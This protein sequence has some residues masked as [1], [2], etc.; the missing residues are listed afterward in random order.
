MKR[1][2]R[3]AVDSSPAVN[4]VMCGVLLLG[5]ASMFMMRREVFPEFSLDIILVSV[6]Y[7][8][9][10]PDEVEQG[11]CQ[12]IEESVRS[13]E[14]IK[15]QTA[16]AQEGS[17]FLVLELQ[18]G[19]DVQKI[20]NDVRSEIDRIPS[21]PVLAEDH[22]VEQITLRESA[23]KVAVQGPELAGVD[24]ELELRE[25]TER[26][27]EDLIQLPAVSQ[28]NILGSR[29]YQIDVEVSEDRLRTYGLTLQ[30][31][32]AKIREENI[33]M[34]GGK[35][36]TPNQEVLVRGKNKRLYGHDIAQIPL[37]TKESGVVLTVGDL[38][39]VSDAFTDDTAISYVNG[40]PALVISMDRT[41][42]EDL[43]KMVDEV[44]RYAD[45][46]TVP[47]GY[48][49]VAFGDRSLEVRDRMNLLMKNGMQGLVLVFLMLTVFM[50]LRLSFWVAL[51]IP[52]AVLGSGIFLLYFGQTLNM[53]SLFAFLMA[54]GIVV[55]DAI[56]I[57]ENIFSHRQKGDGPIEAAINGT[58]EVIPSVAAS[59]TTTIIAFSPLLFVSGVMGKFIA[60]MPV[61]VIAMLVIS[62][63]ESMII[64]PCHLAHSGGDNALLRLFQRHAERPLIWQLMVGVVLT[65]LTLLLVDRILPIVMY[66]GTRPSAPVLMLGWAG[67]GIAVGLMSYVAAY[68]VLRL[69]D[70][71]A[72][73]QRR[74]DRFL[75][76]FIDRYYHSALALSIRH[77]LAVSCVAISVALAS[78]SLV[79]SGKTPFIV[80][81]KTDQNQIQALVTFPDGTPANVT[82]AATRQMMD[83]ILAV[84]REYSAGTSLI[85]FR[86]RAVGQVT[87]PG[88]MGPNT[89][90]DGSHV[91][92]VFIELVESAHR[93]I[94]SQQITDAWR[95]ATG[96]IPGAESLVFGS[97]QIGPG[98]TPIEFKLLAP[99][100]AMSELESAVE[101][102]KARLS[103]YP[104]I[105]DVLDDS[106]P[107]KWE[108]QLT[109]KDK[110]KA[111]GISLTQLARTVRSSYYGD[112]VMRLQ[113]GRHEVKLMVRY[114]PEER[115]SLA[116]FEEIRVRSPDGA[117]YPLTELA[118]VKVERGYSE[119][120]RVD[121]L[122]S[123]TITADVVESVG[124]ARQT[125]SDL[126]ASFMD[127]LLAEHPNVRVRWEGQAEQTR[128]SVQSLFVG[129]LVAVVGMF[130]LLTA[131]FRSYVQPFII[132]GIIP[133]GIIGAIWGHFFMGLPLTI[134]TLF[135]LVALTGVVVNDSIV[136]IDFINLRVNQGMPLYTALAD[137]GRRR[138]RPV[139][140]TSVTTIAGLTPML[141]EKS[142]QA[143]FLIPL[144]A[145]LVFGLL[146]ATGLVLIL[147]PAWYALYRMLQGILSL[148][149]QGGFLS[150]SRAALLG[151]TG[152]D[153]FGFAGT[154]SAE[155]H[156]AT[157]KH[158]G[159]GNGEVETTEHV[160][161][162]A[163]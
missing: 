47:P 52:I 23:I 129:F 75:T 79:A 154:N 30:D 123:I 116:S 92:S 86:R 153:P 152:G 103:E 100:H 161:V 162:T 94:T 142:F 4:T 159:N 134:F 139:L 70:L 118:D 11:I 44:K 45:T 113:R 58:L 24:A 25:V 15:K 143:Q 106:T 43:L 119:I 71:F 136:L 42:S 17:G 145:T 80:F 37:V 88:M 19:V 96:D 98:G 33:E 95:Q 107:G 10:S 83:A 90:T 26:I 99:V 148:F 87:S 28:A 73:L 146:V 163:P 1:V 97:T 55:D 81:P 156:R 137:A 6:P 128:E 141:M 9:A 72:L 76:S 111:M 16:V 54:L 8:G 114:P 48:N 151:L 12:K 130:V 35:M 78:C 5:F 112:E 14:G 38:G 7:P 125:V 85:N 56:V 66:S 31:V 89:R 115:R 104:G 69:G 36:K 41:Q 64:L 121:Q 67:I 140:L 101:K 84:D 13:I 82:D 60:V 59:V 109:I 46:A 102:T 74:T 77:P 50:N 32:A 61:A 155:L 18:T 3:W 110:A 138:F 51:G 157:L 122:R 53:L 40:R 20:L 68:P 93:S 131:E 34:P 135:G 63:F 120:N 65:A 133:F 132:L 160:N 108:F 49:L 105:V 91:G 147:V 22:K 27:R 39:S 62:L 29:E 127:D 57:G 150:A 2:I 144:A 158:S 149:M 126:K 117:E 21:F 124:N